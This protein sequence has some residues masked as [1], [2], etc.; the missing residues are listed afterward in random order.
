MYFHN[1]NE[2]KQL[3]R[4]CGNH[5]FDPDTM[6]FFSSRVGSKVYGGQY[7]ITSEQFVDNRGVA[8]PRRYT[9]RKFT[10][11]N[12]RFDIDTVGEFQQFDTHSQAVKFAQQLG[13]R[14][15]LELA[16]I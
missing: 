10:Y 5:F 15:V 2:I 7:F 16:T 8:D 9:I 4:D 1:V 12:G 14:R 3:A 6:R 11:D 13:A